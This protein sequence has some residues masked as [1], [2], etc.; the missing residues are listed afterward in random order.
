MTLDN[1]P[2]LEKI[3]QVLRPEDTRWILVDHNK[4]QGVLGSVY[5]S[6]VCGVIDHHEDEG[7]TPQDPDLEARVI[8][9]CGSCTSLVIR[10][11]RS[12]WDAI[13]RGTSSKS[14]SPPPSY[15]LIQQD[16][17]SHDSGRAHQAWD[18]QLAKTALGSILIDTANLTA[19]E[20]VEAADLDA[21][22][23]LETKILSP[24]TNEPSPTASSSSS[25][26]NRK[27]FYNDLHTAK[28][29]IDP[30]TLTDILRKDYK[31]WSSSNTNPSQTLGISSV[32]KPLSFLIAKAA[33]ESPESE[34]EAEA[35]TA[36]AFNN[37]IQKFMQTRHLALFAIMTSFST[38]TSGHTR[39]LFLQ[40]S[41][42]SP[43]LSAAAASRFAAHS[44][45]ELGLESLHVAGINSTTATN[46]N[47]DEREKNTDT[48]SQWTRLVWTQKETRKSRKQVAPL[49][50][51][52][53]G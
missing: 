14:T 27:K 30:L 45:A 44:R 1:L 20:K 22:Q 37:T 36:N 23:Y 51:E 2:P 47:A 32:V 52:A 28:Q 38:P 19:K 35:E 24:S 39:E 43:S 3:D 41:P 15:S 6:R 9:K 12:S 17:S 33:K 7:S 11:L 46:P 53:L 26:W 49:L 25:E 8:E 5:S 40:T 13:S 42:D 4:L 34:A 29:N 16:P 21:V 50:R 10:T 18:A 31:Q 48:N